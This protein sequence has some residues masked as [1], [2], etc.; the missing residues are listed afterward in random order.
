MSHAL[1]VAS[2]T[3]TGIQ[4]PATTDAPDALDTF[5][6]QADPRSL[7]LMFLSG[8]V[9]RI[10][11]APATRWIEDRH[12]W[13]SIAG[14]DHNRVELALRRAVRFDGDGEIEFTALDAAG[15]AFAARLVIRVA[16]PIG[17][18]VR[19]WG[20]MTDISHEHRESIVRL[21]PAAS[22]LVA[23]PIIRRA[24]RFVAVGIAAMFASYALAV[25]AIRPM[26]AEP[27]TAV[28]IQRADRLEEALQEH[29]TDEALLEDAVGSIESSVGELVALGPKLAGKLD[30]LTA[31]RAK[32]AE[33][34]ALTPPELA[35]RLRALLAELDRVA[36][37]SSTAPSSSSSEAPATDV[38]A[39]ADDAPDA[40]SPQN[41]P[42]TAPAQAP[43]GAP[44]SVPTDGVT[45]LR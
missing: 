4:A 45:R 41:A 32:I 33:L 39:P 27:P 6:W 29:A 44:S 8:Q 43:T 36:I 15:R 17:A 20:L 7:R 2:A 26:T 42:A 3:T 14:H 10:L 38:D 21:D 16:R 34:I 37:P 9:G 35:G 28:A 1:R 12:P 11:G 18:A 5:M 13:R 30:A 19:L 24:G 22:P 31:L 40:G 25:S 23:P